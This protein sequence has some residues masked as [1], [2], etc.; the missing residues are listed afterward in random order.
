MHRKVVLIAQMA[1]EVY[2]T[3]N[4]YVTYCIVSLQY[5]TIRFWE[6][7][8]CDDCNEYTEMATDITSLIISFTI[9]SKVTHR[10]I[11]GKRYLS[12]T[13]SQIPQTVP[14]LQPNRAKDG[15]HSWRIQRRS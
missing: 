14:H 4:T 9:V 10:N 12:I 11:F 8:L 15:L 7:Q 6:G 3:L 2:E 13:A 5:D 1:V